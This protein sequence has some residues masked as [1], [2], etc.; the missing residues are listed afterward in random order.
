MKNTIG[1]ALRVSFGLWLVLGLGCAVTSSLVKGTGPSRI[2]GEQL[3]TAN[4]N[5]CHNARAA[6]EFADGDWEVILDHMR[7][8]AG[9]TGDETQ[10]VL[11]Y[12][13]ENN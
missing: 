5:R 4:C 13:Q 10:S 8:V 3:W 6:Q 11:K 7:V 9:L 1:V 12:L 2:T